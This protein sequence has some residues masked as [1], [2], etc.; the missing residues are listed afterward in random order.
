MSVE[1]KTGVNER[2][3][4]FAINMTIDGCFDHTAMIADDELHD[5]YTSLLNNV[6]AVLFGRKTYQLMESF[7]PIAYED[8]L[9][10]KS[11]L[12]FADKI[13][14]IPKI[15]FSKT[16]DKVNWN[17][18]TL[19]TGNIVEEVLK[20]KQ[21]E[22]SENGTE[23]EDLKYR[24]GISIGSLSIASIFMKLNLIDEYWF[25]VHPVI[26]GKGKRLFEGI[27]DP[28]DGNGRLNLKL[29]STETF[30]S[31]VVVLHYEK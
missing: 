15:V 17:N 29:I 31:G 4:I 25:V 12:A 3:L 23:E 21:Q 16:L 1:I 13:N 18:T 19:I 9:A 24:P 22:A 6:D 14:N 11:I 10:T 27:P 28:F 30:K 20:L 26:L 7:W 5:F 2:K 8:S